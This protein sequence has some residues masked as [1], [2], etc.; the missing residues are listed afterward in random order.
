MNNNKA[1]QILQKCYIQ[2]PNGHCATL[3][4]A[5]LEADA[6]DILNALD[7]QRPEALIMIAGAASDLSEDTSSHLTQLCNLGIMPVVKQ[8][9]AMIIDGGTEVGVI[10]LIGMSA[11]EFDQRLNLLG[12]SSAGLVTYP[13]GPSIKTELLDMAAPLDPNHSYF[14]LAEAEI[15]GSETEMMYALAELIS[16][17]IP[18]ISLV[19][20][21]GDISKNE[22]LQ[23]VRRGWPLL[24]I[25]G[26]GRL[27]D[28]I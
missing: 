12:V 3:V 21:G 2:F 25:E 1:K 22:V 24:I 9:K 13:G 23:S 14:V 11:N 6:R 26:T 27:A 19:V 16:K 17:D 10:R 4:I 20:N 15:W 5:P 8:K 7:I 28:E 18:V